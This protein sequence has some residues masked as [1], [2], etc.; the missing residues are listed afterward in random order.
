[1]RYLTRVLGRESYWPLDGKPD[2]VHATDRGPAVEHLISLR[3][4]RILG[5]FHWLP[6]FAPTQAMRFR[7]HLISNAYCSNLST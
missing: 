2:L 4:I 7:L 3:P 6:T 5:G 1:M